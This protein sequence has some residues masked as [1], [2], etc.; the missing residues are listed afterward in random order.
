ML[1]DHMSCIVEGDQ[2]VVNIDRDDDEDLGLQIVKRAGS[3]G[4]TGF[5]IVKSLIPG[6]PA[7][8]CNKLMENDIIL[9]VT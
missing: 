4:P 8:C 2:F 3:H 9:Q 5:F 7:H 1:L 6:S